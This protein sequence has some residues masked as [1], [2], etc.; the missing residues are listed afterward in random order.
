MLTPKQLEHCPDGMVELYAQLESDILAD[1]ARRIATYDYFIPSAQWQFEKQKELGNLSK[2]II[3]TLSRATGKSEDELR[4]LM[5]QAGAEALAA[6]DEIYRTAGKEPPPVNQSKALLAVLN[7][8]YKKNDKLFKNLTK[9]T[10]RTA[11]GQFEAALDRAHLQIMSGA[12]D[13]NTAIRNAV[14]N[15]SKQGIGAVKYPSGHTDTIEAAVRRATVTGVNQ[16]CIQL[17]LARA[18]EM[19]CDLVETT[20]HGG[21]RPEHA[22]WQGRVFSLSGEHGKYPDFYKSTGYGTGAGLG[23][24]NC[25]H[26]FSPFFEGISKAAYSKTELKDYEAKKYRFNGVKM[27]EYEASQKQRYIERQKRRWKRE[28]AAMAAAGLDTSESAA[29]IAKWS[30]IEKDFCRQTGLKRQAERS[31]IGAKTAGKGLNG[32]AKSGIIKNID[33]D[34]LDFVTYNTG[35]KEEVVKYIGSTV[36]ELE[37]SLGVRFNYVSNEIKSTGSHGTA[38]FQTEPVSFGRGK[39]LLQLNINTEVLAGKSIADIDKMFKNADNTIVNSL[40][41]ALVHETG[42]AKLISGLTLNQVQDLYKYL[43]QPDEKGL[44]NSISGIAFADGAEAIAEIEVLFARGEKVPDEL[45]E[46]YMMFIGRG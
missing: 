19:G 28:N 4:R 35:M 13:Q 3:K 29:K 46:F 43:L 39:V 7:A 12:F 36:K 9:T 31:F 10:A 15:L 44:F 40:H 41:D 20:A 34:D 2:D 21:A 42:H 30:A 6:D 11:T 25:R 32:A 27:T 24:W 38:I 8:A 5:S 16:T 14:K 33:L 18:E 45:K 26:S 1:M 22:V 17:Q 23:G 37:Q